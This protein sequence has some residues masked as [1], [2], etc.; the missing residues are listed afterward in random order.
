MA[1]RT[2]DGRPLRILNIVDEYTRECLRIQVGRK[3]KAVDV[4]CEL[5]D[6]FIERGAPEYLRSDNGS[7]FTADSIRG[8][9]QRL[10]VKT[11]LIEPGSPWENGYV[12]SFNGKMR[13]ELLNGEIFDTILEAQVVTEAWRKEYN[14]IRPHSSL[15]YRAPAPEAHSLRQVANA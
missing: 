11:L 9:L 6:L 15:G 4:I 13:D 2:S 1:E 3:M 8:W 7:E 5:S 14:T 10:G 12:E